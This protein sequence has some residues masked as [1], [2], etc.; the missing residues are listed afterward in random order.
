MSLAS[1]RQG[2]SLI[3]ATVIRETRQWTSK[4]FV[5]THHKFGLVT[6]KRREWEKLILQWVVSTVWCTFWSTCH[7]ALLR[8][9]VFISEVH[10]FPLPA[11]SI[12]GMHKCPG[13]CFS[14]LGSKLCIDVLYARNTFLSIESFLS[15]KSESS[16]FFY[17]L[18]FPIIL[19][20]LRAVEG[21]NQSI[22]VESVMEILSLLKSFYRQFPVLSCEK[23]DSKEV[24]R[25]RKINLCKYDACYFVFP[26]KQQRYFPQITFHKVFLY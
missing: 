2:H 8:A 5:C 26:I 17:R 22:F 3:Q 14:S 10:N 7:Q 21:W 6:I 24:V 18:A 12:W 11:T 23:Q 16:L 9:A 13:W 1:S 15:P 20:E 19:W 4:Y 25:N